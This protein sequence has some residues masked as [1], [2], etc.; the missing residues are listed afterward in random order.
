VETGYDPDL[1]RALSHRTSDAIEA[2][3][4][5]H[6][7][8]PAAADALRT[9]RL[10]RHNLEDLWMP[11]LRRIV[12]S[13][14]MVSW[15]DS[16]LDGQTSRST[17]PLQGR[18]RSRPGMFSS[19]T[20]DD[21]LDRVSWVDRLEGA[22]PDYAEL[23]DL[24]ALAEELARRVRSDASFGPQVIALVP[25]TIVIGAL[26]ARADF[27][28]WFLSA[29]I[30]SMVEPRTL[31]AVVDPDLYAA[32]L[33]SALRAATPD[34][35][36]CLDLLADESVLRGIAGSRRLD[37]TVVGQ[38]TVSALDASVRADPTRIT[39]GYGVLGTLIELTNGPFE[40]GINTG[41][42]VGVA[43]SMAGYLP[44]FAPALDFEGA[45]PVS[46]SVDGTRIEL[47]TYDDLV[48][49][50]SVVLRDPAAQAAIAPAVSGYAIHTVNALGADVG[51]RTGVEHVADFADLLVDATERGQVALMAEA[52]AEEGRRR[53]FGNAIGFGLGVTAGVLGG[54]VAVRAVV[55]NAIALGTAFAA[56]VNPAEMPDRLFGPTTYD[57]ITLTAVR[58]VVDDPDV[59]DSAG[60]DSIDDD[61]L[62]EIAARLDRLDRETDV[63][64][65]IAG[66]R[67]LNRWIADNVPE[68][69]AFLTGVKAMPGM[70]ALKE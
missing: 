38:F 31:A 17:H 8:D 6:S 59:R 5:I 21:L 34:P 18:R 15:T 40:R 24:D 4:A 46:V 64:A 7:D 1:V 26:T 22:G 9:I 63:A 2:L 29:V 42:A 10:T 58:N 56:R 3:R 65:H 51:E 30:T 13:D 45:S 54:S 16:R 12:D 57:L 50:F 52:A 32:S 53:R 20:D 19:C 27:P 41:L 49:L 11:A 39:D 44:T 68:L 23:V 69:D 60:L 61:D 55:T 36:T 62:D 37:T 28:S 43:G 70:D 33:S 67:D 47:G 66:V 35:Q 14:A 25:T 48:G